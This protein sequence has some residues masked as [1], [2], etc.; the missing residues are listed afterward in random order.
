[1][2]LTLAAASY[3]LL[4]YL[5]SSIC[6]V[7]SFSLQQ[8]RTR[9]IIKLDLSVADPIVIQD[10]LE[11]P[12]CDGKQTHECQTHFLTPGLKAQLRDSLGGDPHGTTAK[13]IAELGKFDTCRQ[14]LLDDTIITCLIKN[15]NSK[16]TELL[17]QSSRALAN[18]CYDVGE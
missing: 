6:I 5:P 16:N 4:K 1:M 7:F 8:R 11:K 13:I 15:L 10:N 14:F 17:T 18:L 2:Y 12:C 9:M 3:T